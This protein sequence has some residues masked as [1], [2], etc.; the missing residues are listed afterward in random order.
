VNPVLK[1]I[2]YSVVALALMMGIFLLS[3]CIPAEDFLDTAMKTPGKE[4]C[5]TLQREEVKGTACV[6]FTPEK[7]VVPP[8]IP[9][10]EVK[11]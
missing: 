3:A 1:F 8:V 11:P 6:V 5:A 10:V 2:L 7:V 4:V 9:P